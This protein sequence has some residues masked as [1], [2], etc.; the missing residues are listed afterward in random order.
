LL[1]AAQTETATATVTGIAPVGAGTHN[2]E[3]SYGG[4]SHYARSV[5]STVPLTAGLAPPVIAPASGS[6]ATEVKVTI[7]EAI[8][9]ATIYYQAWGSVNTNGYV[10]Y[11]GPFFLSYGGYEQIQAYATETGY[12]Q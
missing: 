5:S 11:T 12:Q 3:A 2:V 6:Y 1:Q 8:P 4:D 7:T 9:G 10:Q